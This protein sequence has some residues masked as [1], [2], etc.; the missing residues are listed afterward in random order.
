M[1]MAAMRCALFI[2]V[3]SVAAHAIRLP[4]PRPA[5][6]A[7]RAPLRVALPLMSDGGE[8]SPNMVAVILPQNQKPGD[9]IVIQSPGGQ[10]FQVVVP[11]GVMPGD[12][13]QVQLPISAYAPAEEAAQ[14]PTSPEA[15]KV[16]QPTPTAP[17]VGGQGLLDNLIT[18]DSNPWVTS[19]AERVRAKYGSRE[20]FVDLDDAQEQLKLK[21]LEQDLAQFKAMQGG[22][23]VAVEDDDQELSLLKRTI[24]TLGTVLT[25]NFFVII[26][27]FMWFLAGVGMQ[28]GAHDEGLINSFRGAWDSLIM[29]LLTT[30]MT[31]TFLSAGLEKLAKS[32][33]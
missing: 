27:F 21:Q 26:A 29:P 3:A 2:M 4:A 7:W 19:K 20:R 32:D 15:P 9:T 23:K 30:H 13:F 14:S 11:E 25:F 22:S 33:A 24:D 31:L 6:V 5:L 16:G 17:E 1:A 12:Q 8:A 28:F 10:R 18:R